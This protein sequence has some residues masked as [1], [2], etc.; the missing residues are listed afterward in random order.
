MPPK[1]PPRPNGAAHP[2][3]PGSDTVTDVAV[4][5]PAESAGPRTVAHRPTVSAAEVAFAVTV[6][7]V[8]ELV[9]TVFDD[10]APLASFTETVIVDP[11]TAVTAPA[12]GGVKERLRGA[13]GRGDAF[14]RPEGRVPVPARN[15]PV[16]A[17]LTAG[18]IATLVTA[19]P[20]EGAGVEP[21]ADP[22][23]LDATTQA[24]TVT[25]EIEPLLDWSTMVVGATV[26][27]VCAVW[28]CTCIVVPVTAAIW[29]KMPP[30]RPP[31]PWPPP[32]PDCCDWV[33]AGAAGAAA[34]EQP[35]SRRATP[36][37]AAP[38]ARRR[39]FVVSVDMG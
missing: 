31:A 37:T 36:R 4:T 38:R 32:P 24:P 28:L 26:T 39:G 5:V 3:A 14:G 15:P 6:N 11:D 20:E 30:P 2:L 29:P 13:D 35:A 12:T 25:S 7:A 22:P 17:P 8:E 34:A 1:P 9:V 18:V 19:P 27:A 16:Q 21:V 23:K 33:E 10:V